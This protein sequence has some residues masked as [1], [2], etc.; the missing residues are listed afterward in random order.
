MVSHGRELVEAAERSE[1]E[2]RARLGGGAAAADSGRDLVLFWA[3]RDPAWVFRGWTV[4][5]GLTLPLALPFPD[6]VLTAALIGAVL[7]W[8]NHKAFRLEL[9]ARELRLRPGLLSPTRRW[10]LAAIGLVEARDAEMR[11]IRWG[12]PRPPVGHVLIELPDGLLDIAGLKEPQELAEAIETL[13]AGAGGPP[14][15]ARYP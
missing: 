14:G 10:P 15:P 11:R 3:E 8:L 4:L 7:T 1:S 5:T 13:R 12:A 2:A 9:T 6:A